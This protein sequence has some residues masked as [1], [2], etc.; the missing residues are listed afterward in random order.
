MILGKVWRKWIEDDDGV[1]L[2]MF[3]KVIS[4]RLEIQENVY[5][6]MVGVRG[7]G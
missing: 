5:T 3:S 2:E 6:Y 4:Y 7:M 1:M